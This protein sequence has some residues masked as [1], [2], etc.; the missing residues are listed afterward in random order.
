[1]KRLFLITLLSIVTAFSQNDS[2]DDLS[3]SAIASWT[4]EGKEPGTL[5]GGAKISDKGPQAPEHPVF[6]EGNEALT[7]GS[8]GDALRV[9]ESDFPDKN[10]RFTNGD[11]ITLEAWVKT[12]ALQNERY[13]YLIG[14][15]R[16]Q[17]KGFTKEN[18]N[19][20]L[21]LKGEN[22][23]AKP[24]FLFRSR[25]PENNKEEYHRWIAADGFVTGGWHH[26]AVTYTF[27][28]PES[29]VAFVDGSKITDGAWDMAGPTKLPPV[30]DADDIMIGT[31]NGG[32]T[33]N[34]LSGSL[35]NVAIYR[36]NLPDS[37]LAERY[38]FIPPPPSLDPE[39]IPAGKV[40]VQ[41]C[42]EGLGGKAA[43]PGG[44]PQA[45]ESYEAPAFGFSELPHKYV[46]TG[47]ARRQATAI[48]P[49]GRSESD[50]SEGQ[51]PPPPP[52]P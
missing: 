44:D 20:A 3:A 18:Q 2:G 39:K 16:N 7:L 13:A 50:F 5:V 25:N 34:T 21:R 45:T 40:L 36:D 9:K 22:G 1:M 52:R 12:G 19:W 35:D 46:S 14:K 10:F 23:V 51:T 15:G 49:S 17:T 24:S 48:L 47:R 8:A 30:T 32:G 26:V 11:T 31:G 42:E 37:A 33:N 29:I 43:W 27:G 4:F 28:K 38:V 41:I 6:K